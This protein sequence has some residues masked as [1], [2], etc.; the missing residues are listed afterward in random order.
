MHDEYHF[1]NILRRDKVRV[2][3]CGKVGKNFDRFDKIEKR[4]L[5]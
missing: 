5:C 4:K 1:R 2:Y 3:K